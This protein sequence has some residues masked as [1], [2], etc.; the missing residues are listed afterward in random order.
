MV[1]A[2]PPPEYQQLIIAIALI[3]TFGAMIYAYLAYRKF[4]KGD[5]KQNVKFFL[6]AG[7]LFGISFIARAIGLMSNTD[8]VVFRSIDHTIYMFSFFF[9]LIAIYNTY[10]LTKIYSIN[11]GRKK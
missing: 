3:I 7:Y 6:I 2:F 8:P 1:L 9:T 10:K 11:V 4:T 5:F